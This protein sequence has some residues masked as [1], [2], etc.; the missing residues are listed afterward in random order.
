MDSFEN[1][2]RILVSGPGTGKTTRIVAEIEKFLKDEKYKQQGFIVCTFTRNAATELKM[3]LLQKIDYSLL[4]NRPYLI[5]TIH[6][7]SMEILKTHPSGDFSDSVI[8][9][10]DELPSY[11]NSKLAKLGFNRENYKGGGKLW[12]LCSNIVDIFSL[13]TDQMIQIKDLDFGNKEDIES[14]VANYPMYL[15][16]LE[17]DN[18]LD[19]AMV[20]SELLRVLREDQEFRE[21]VSK[22]YCHI[23][24]DEYQDTNYMQNALMIELARPACNIT[25]VGDDDQSIYAFRG[26]HVENLL[27]FPKTILKF[28]HDIEPLYLSAN[29]RSTGKI[30]EFNNAYIDSVNIPRFV[31]KIIPH[32]EDEGA[33]PVIREFDSPGDEAMWIVENIKDLREAGKIKSYS[34]IA[35]LYRTAKFQSQAVQDLLLAADIPFEMIGVGD[36]FEQFFMDDALLVLDFVLNRDED[37]MDEFMQAMQSL[38]PKLYEFYA[39]D[40]VVI[41]LITIKDELSEYGSCISLLYD[42]FI[43]TDFLGRYAQHKENLGELTQLVLNYDENVKAFDVYWLRSYIRYLKNERKIDYI[44]QRRTDAVKIHT[45]HR[46]KGLEFHTVFLPHQTKSGVRPSMLDSFRD[47]AG[48]PLNVIDDEVRLFYVG[49]TRAKNALFISRPRASATGLRKYESSSAFKQCLSLITNWDSEISMAAVP[50]SS[51][52]PDDLINDPD[53]VISYNAI[54]TFTICPRM[55]MYSSVWR[56][57][58]V[59]T[60]GMQFGS[61]IHRILQLVNIKIKNGVSHEDIDIEALVSSNWKDNWFQD[62]KTNE[63]FRKSGVKQIQSYLQFYKNSM[64]DYEIFGIEEEFDIVAEKQMISGRFDLTLK[65]NDDY[66]ILDFKTGDVAD[67]SSQLTFYGLCFEQKYN[68]R[69]PQL[70]VYYLKEG[71]LV[72]SIAGNSAKEL[73]SILLISEKI[74]NEEFG[75]TPGHH[76][77][78]CAFSNICEFSTTLK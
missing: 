42:I 58:T 41:K 37:A 53:F 67:Y 73:E 68:T 60:G 32:R 43:A 6:S 74:K 35:I 5:G 44:P 15:K 33:K 27:E 45:I 46:A 70:L 47:I 63:N 72:E 56:L 11:I 29:Y 21:A 8:I 59:R 57:E 25:V 71:L 30:V 65:R 48:I 24:V 54:R 14:I 3:R 17:K 38:D 49:A 1:G 31:K 69:K 52:N 7:I 22:T 64:K 66:A 4:S 20:Q 28:G 10:E 50:I 12:E 23:F 2:P 9:T 61:N 75:A 36:Y 51:S 19:F 16:I 34:D 18:K 77:R 76:C 13:I 62:N 40:D 78:D 26:A 39:N 55:Y